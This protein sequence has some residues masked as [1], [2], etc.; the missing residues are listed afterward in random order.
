[1]IPRMISYRRCSVITIT[2]AIVVLITITTR[3]PTG[4]QASAIRP[5]SEQQSVSDSEVVEITRHRRDTVPKSRTLV[6]NKRTLHKLKPL[7]LLPARLALGAGSKLAAGARLGA[8]AVHVGS[9]AV[10]AGSKAL[11]VG[12]VGLRAVKKVAKV[13]VKAATALG[14]KAVLLNFLF[15]VILV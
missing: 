7:L 9:Q 6:R 15:Q 14:V 13:T 3:L 10:H 5:V 1:M 11:S 4:T 8:K 2:A 12:L